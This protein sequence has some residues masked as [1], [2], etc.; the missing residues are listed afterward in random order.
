MPQKQAHKSRC[1]SRHGMCAIIIILTCLVHPSTAAGIKHSSVGRIYRMLYRFPKQHGGVDCSACT[2]P[3]PPPPHTHTHT[4]YIHH[5]M[6]YSWVML[7]HQ[8]YYT[9]PIGVSP[10]HYHWSSPMVLRGPTSDTR[11]SF[12]RVMVAH[13]VMLYMH[14]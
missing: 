4:Q 5:F 7:H 1:C 11:S 9:R 12:T 2:L 10:H 3:Y 8:W 6:S 14:T 13:V